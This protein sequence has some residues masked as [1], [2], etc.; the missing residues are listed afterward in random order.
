[1]ESAQPFSARFVT[2]R[3]Q[4]LAPSASNATV[5]YTST[6]PLA[7]GRSSPSQA[8]V[9]PPSARR[10]RDLRDGLWFCSVAIWPGLP[11]PTNLSSQKSAVLPVAETKRQPPEAL[12]TM[13][14]TA[15]PLL[16]PLNSM[17]SESFSKVCADAQ[18]ATAVNAPK[19]IRFMFP[20]YRTITHVPM[21]A[22]QHW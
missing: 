19:R 9:A 21:K 10:R 14:V 7:S 4:R 17:A 1:M 12:L 18:T 15:K 2:E 20:P 5:A 22:S 13:P 6:A 11:P 3:V 16:G 8:N